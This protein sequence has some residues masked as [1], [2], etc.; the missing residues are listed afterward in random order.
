VRTTSDPDDDRGTT[1][2]PWRYVWQGVPRPF[3]HP[4]TTPAGRVLSRDAPE[5]H[6]WHHALWFTIKFVNGENFWEEYD[7]FGLLVQSEPP[8][9]RTDD[10]GRVHARSTIRWQRPGGAGVAV[11]ELCDLSVAIVDDAV[12]CDWDVRLAPTDDTVFDRTP[13]TTWGGYGGLTLRGRGD[14]HDTELR[15]PDGQARPRVLGD[16]AEWLALEGPLAADDTEVRAD[17]HGDATT[18]DAEVGIALFEH[19]D[20][21]SFPT[22]WYASTRADTYGQDGWSNFANAAFLWDG[23]LEVAAG[24]TLRLRHRVLTHDGRWV[25]E[26]LQREWE[27]WAD[28]AGAVHR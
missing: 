11:E 23:P 26:R 27:T 6:W 24:H 21:P 17:S 4:V 9:L 8:E 3:V 25:T 7:E 18:T 22:P 19:P 1:I 2:G 28:D 12:I 15:L 14:W 5:D 20:N 13:F 16:R 10:T